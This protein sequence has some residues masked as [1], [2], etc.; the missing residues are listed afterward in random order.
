MTQRCSARSPRS[1]RQ[2][3][4]EPDFHALDGN[5]SF[6]CGNCITRIGT[7][8]PMI[9]LKTNLGKARRVLT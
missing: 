2:K 3:G 6:G 4:L 7:S 1:E 8:Y 5:V 9:Q